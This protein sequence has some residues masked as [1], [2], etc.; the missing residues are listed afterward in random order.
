M[1]GSKYWHVIIERDPGYV[2]DQILVGIRSGLANPDSVDW[3][4]LRAEFRDKV[5]VIISSWWQEMYGPLQELWAAVVTYQEGLLCSACEADFSRFF[6]GTT[7]KVRQPAAADIG[8]AALKVMAASDTFLT[9][10]VN[11]PRIKAIAQLVCGKVTDQFTCLGTSHIVDLAINALTKLN[12]RDMLCGDSNGDL[13]T[14]N[15]HCKDFMFNRVLRG[16]FIDTEPIL[17]NIFD[18]LNKICLKVP[19]P[20]MDCGPI[21]IMS[22]Q[23]SSFYFTFDERPLATNEYGVDGFDIKNAACDSN[24]SGFACG[25]S[26]PKPE[27]HKGNAPADNSAGN[28]GA[29]IITIVILLTLAAVGAVVFISRERIKRVTQSFY[30]RMRDDG[31]GPT[32]GL[33]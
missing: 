9:S 27:S 17:S 16:L 26:G 32:V 30:T 22:K 25:Q 28:S 20:K 15:R 19:F 13:D 5:G 11:Q 12:M 3:K 29:I 1:Q 7:I 24:L 21:D 10:T 18:Y 6:N 2:V 31:M 33:V 8:D 4:G 23:L 14:R